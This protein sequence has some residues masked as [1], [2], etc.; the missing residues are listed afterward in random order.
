MSA[1]LQPVQSERL[2]EQKDRSYPLLLLQ[3]AKTIRTISALD[4]PKIIPAKTSLG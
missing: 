4:I 3:I 2:L 1:P